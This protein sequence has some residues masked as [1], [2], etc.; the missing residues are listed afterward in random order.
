MYFY[1]VLRPFSYL[2][3]KHQ[4]KKKF[5]WVI[6]L[7]L[8]FTSSSI[9]YFQDVIV[10]WGKNGI[11]YEVYGLIQILPGFYIAA[12]A[13]IATF[14]KKD[15]DFLMPDPAPELELMIDSQP[16]TITITRRR[17]LCLLFS[18]LTALSLI[19]SLFCI[20]SEPAR[21]ITSSI[22]PSSISE[23]VSS[24]FFLAYMLFFWQLITTTLLGLYYLGEKIH[25]E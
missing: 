3:I 13:A 10:L 5:D 6:P 15:L 2:K 24:F 19:L 22:I 23:A 21:L 9:C 4:L 14:K 11:V 25:N 18:Y 1:E 7:F 17:F 16:N 8:T 20:L 12:L